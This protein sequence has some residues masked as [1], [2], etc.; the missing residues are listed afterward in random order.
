MMSRPTPGF[1]RQASGDCAP[2]SGFLRQ[3]GGNKMSRYR[4]AV[5]TGGTFSDFVI[6][7]VQSGRWSIIK[8]PSTPAD[9]SLAI[10]SGV[11]ELLQSGIHAGDVCFFSHGTTVATNALLEG[12]GARV[13]LLVTEGFSATYLVGHQARGHGEAL[14]DLLFE[15]PIPLVPPSRTMEVPERV[16]SAGTVVCPLDLQGAGRAITA[17]RDAGAEAI[18]ICFLFSFLYP[19]HE[20]QVRALAEELAPG[21]YITASADVLPLVREYPRMSTTVVNAYIGPILAKYIRR[22]GSG[23]DDVGVTPPQRYIMQSNG[24]TGTFAHTARQAVS[25]V[26]SGPAGGVM[27]AVELGRTAG[28]PDLITFDMGGTSCDVALIHGLQPGLT[29]KGAV[30]GWDVAVPMLDIHTVSAGGGTIARVDTHGVLRVGPDSAGADPG[31]ASYGLGGREVTVTD[32][33]LSLGFLSSRHLLA[34]RVRL[35]P[36]LAADVIQ[37]NVAAPLGLGLPEAAAGVVRLVEVQMAEA[38]KAISTRRGYDVRGFTLV[39]FGGA[40]PI[41]AGRVALELGIPQVL[42]PPAPGCNSA[43]GLLMTDVRHDYVRS[44]LSPLRTLA[45]ADVAGLFG[46]LL[47]EAAATLA[48]EGFTPDQIEMEPAL[49]LRYAG[50]GYE[51]TVPGLAAPAA[52]DLAD[53]RT[54][55]DSAHRQAFG[56]AAPEAPV[57]VVSYRLTAWGRVPRVPLPQL[58]PAREPVAGAVKERRAVYLLEF[59]R[60]VDCPVYDRARLAPG[61]AFAGPAVVEQLDATTVVYPGQQATVDSTGNLLIRTQGGPVA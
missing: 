15:K 28:L 17:V 54:R 45:P 47:D 30:A 20:R 37:R 12:K 16:D 39:A 61:H 21:C 49:D 25:T 5:D 6:Q 8:V 33:N 34:G 50:Q 36:D 48:A 40:G 19:E 26:L 2:E 55:F 59:G 38:V 7:D 52:A 35:N 58:P 31:P 32:C 18:A 1:T 56:H 13:G 29:T 57:E 10:V 53:L 11:R 42:V 51:L 4:V 24:G 60:Y 9:P 22:L 14:F 43:L 46:E 41:H 3:I 27:A 44:R 23:L